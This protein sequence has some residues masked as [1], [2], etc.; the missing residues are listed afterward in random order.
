[1]SDC[2]FCGK[3]IPKGTGM[4]FVKKDGKVLHFCR[5]KCEKNQLKLKRTPAKLLWTKEGQ[6]AK[7]ERMKTLK[8]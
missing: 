7:S 1:M 5:M 3:E 6:K 4:M 2:S 8:K